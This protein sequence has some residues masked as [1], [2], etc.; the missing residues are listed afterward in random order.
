MANIINIVYGLASLLGCGASIATLALIWYKST[1][2]NSDFTNI[3]FSVIGTMV[4]LSLSTAAICWA[5]FKKEEKFYKNELDKVE[6]LKRYR[7]IFN[8]V[9]TAL[10]NNHNIVHYERDFR[11]RLS[12]VIKAR[13]TSDV[14]VVN[15]VLD[16]LI[17]YLSTLTQSVK[18]FCDKETSSNCAVSIKL[19][20]DDQTKTLFRDS[21]SNRHRNGCDFDE[22]GNKIKTHIN[23]N[24]DFKSI[25]QNTKRGN[26]Y[27][28]SN[29]LNDIDENLYKNSTDG[30]KNKYN[31]VLVCPIEYKNDQGY[32]VIGF[33]CVD[34]LQADMKNQNLINYVGTSADLLYG[35]FKAVIEY[36]ASLE[37]SL[38][39]N[40][41]IHKLVKVLR[42]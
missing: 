27:F 30:W 23:H 19:Y 12:E 24:T 2:I 14:G 33:L 32:D 8:N 17:N 7:D 11:I 38:I 34:S 4:V 5:A 9:S 28:A 29:N 35:T 26:R 39:T 40:P 18:V 16:D 22:Q 21:V 3:L 25:I 6:A 10:A 1:N 41:K 37:S 31:S 15:K 42:D 13:S 36:S 20:K